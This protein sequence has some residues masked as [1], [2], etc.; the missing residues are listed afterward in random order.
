MPWDMNVTMEEEKVEVEELRDALI[1]SVAAFAQAIP[2]MAAQGQ[3]P[4]K[5]ISAIAEAIRGRLAGDN[6]ED[7]ISKAFAPTPPPESPE[8]EA[9]G[10]P[11]A[12]GVPGQAPAGAA[13]AGPNAPGAMPPQG[14]QPP[15]SMQNLLAGLSSSGQP[16][17]SA[18]VARKQPA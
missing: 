15:M 18:N 16:N 14:G 5:A 1:Q 4:S 12:Q 9:P 8:G 17:L 11:P 7:V 2:S 3:D 10:Q 6:I 13:P